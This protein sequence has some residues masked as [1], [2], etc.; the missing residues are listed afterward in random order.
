MF[1]KFTNF[2]LL[3]FQ[4]EVSVIRG[5][6]FKYHKFFVFVYCRELVREL[7]C[8]APNYIFKIARRNVT[9]NENFLWI[10]GVKI[11]HFLGHFLGGELSCFDGQKSTPELSCLVGSKSG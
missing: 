4:K 1:L 5:V 3:T 11:G 10:L 9:V 2:P 7:F 8:N 6:G